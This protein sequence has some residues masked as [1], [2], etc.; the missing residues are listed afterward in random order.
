MYFNNTFLISNLQLISIKIT[1]IG[2]FNCE[3]T[4]H[5][6]LKMSSKLSIYVTRLNETLIK[7]YLDINLKMNC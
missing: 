6:K 3:N 5:E 1:K 4:K 7:F 2:I